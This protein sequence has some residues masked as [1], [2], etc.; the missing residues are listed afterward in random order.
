MSVLV[1]DRTAT[2]PRVLVCDVRSCAVAIGPAS[3]EVP[4]QRLPALL[5]SIDLIERPHL[6]LGFCP[7]K[8]RGKLDVHLVAISGRLCFAAL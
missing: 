1:L 5:A 4:R 2:R 8:L 6:E 7:A 3:L